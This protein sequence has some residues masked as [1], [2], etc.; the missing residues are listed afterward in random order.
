[1][2]HFSCLIAISSL[3]HVDTS[4][5][6]E[7]DPPPAPDNGTVRLDD[8][9]STTFGATATQSCNAGYHLIGHPTIQCLSSGSWSSSASCKVTRLYLNN[10]F[11]EF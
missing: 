8:S 11:E 4:S 2:Q 7:C 9:N 6:S 3:L 10:L 1:M 5:F